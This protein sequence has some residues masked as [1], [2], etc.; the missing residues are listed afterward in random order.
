MLTLTIRHPTDAT[1]SVRL[2]G[3]RLADI[4]A[5]AAQA[6]EA[7]GLTKKSKHPITLHDLQLMTAQGAT[8]AYLKRWHAETRAHL[9][10]ERTHHRRLMGTLIVLDPYQAKTC[11]PE[12]IA[13]KRAIARRGEKAVATLAGATPAPAPAPAPAP[14]T[15]VKP[16]TPAPAPRR[17]GRPRKTEKND[18]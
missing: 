2:Q 8:Q 13:E 7:Y 10:C 4:A 18:V 6:M 16:E 1:Q 9:T 14:L 17:R 15:D 3:V 5:P 11:S 12:I